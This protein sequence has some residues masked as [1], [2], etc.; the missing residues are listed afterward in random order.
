MLGDGTAGRAITVRAHAFSASA[1]E[2]IAA[3]GG[4]AEL[5]G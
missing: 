4:T 5:I 2:R 1:R 3:D